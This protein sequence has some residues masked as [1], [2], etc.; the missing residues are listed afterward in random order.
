MDR[1]MK[2]IDKY[3]LRQF[4]VPLA[5]CL[6]TFCMLFVIFD[7][8]EHLSDF[9][10]AKTPFLQILRY[11]FYY[12]P[13]MLVYILPI[14]LLLGLLYGRYLHDERRAAEYLTRATEK[15]RDPRKLAMAPD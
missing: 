14:S 5:Y 10:D 8:F 6:L 13:S 3:I 9:I 12:F 4:F 7:L 1:P 2:L 11:Y 15:L